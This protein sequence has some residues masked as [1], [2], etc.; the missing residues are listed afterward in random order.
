[1]QDNVFDL[2][3]DVFLTASEIRLNYSISYYDSIIIST[4]INAGCEILY[5]EDMQN[6][7]IINQKLKIINPFQTP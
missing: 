4:A 7:Q 5:S 6:N 1:M 3:R 2:T